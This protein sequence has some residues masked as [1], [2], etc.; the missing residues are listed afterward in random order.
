MKKSVRDN[1]LLSG[2]A[3]TVASIILLVLV[4]TKPADPP[5]GY[6]LKLGICVLGWFIVLLS[7]PFMRQL[8]NI[9]TLPE[10]MALP[11][12]FAVLGVFALMLIIMSL[13]SASKAN[14]VGLTVIGVFLW[15][16]FSIFRHRVQ[17][18]GR[19]KR[20]KKSSSGA[21]GKSRPRKKTDDRP[22]AAAPPVD[23]E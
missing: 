11:L 6:W 7:F 18:K 8:G 17:E 21:G 2:M 4:M 1:Y 14:I 9:P 10:K 12:I 19:K 23:Q 15:G 5:L 3:F 13:A 20:S 16:I 22:V